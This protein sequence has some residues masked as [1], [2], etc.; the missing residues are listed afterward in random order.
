MIAKALAAL[1]CGYALFVL[2]RGRLWLPVTLPI[3]ARHARW[4]AGLWLG[5][6]LPA[7]VALAIWGKLAT[8]GGLAV[9]FAPL[10]RAIDLLPGMIGFGT[11]AAGLAGGSALGLV[12]TWWRARRGRAPWTAGDARSIMPQ[13][14]GELLPA[15]LLAVSA[16]VTEELFFRLALPLAVA[17]LS[18]SGL[19]GCVVGTGCFALQ[20]RYQGWIGVVATAIGGALMTGLYFGS[21]GLWLPIVAHALTDLN[22][23]VL[24][25]AVSAWLRRR[26]R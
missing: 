7:L 13:D 24:R 20:H 19:A 11:V 12:A 22:A 3:G 26:R 16:G 8:I 23:L 9:E 2:W 6:G 1:L 21:G 4:A 25:P 18:G 15:A 5:Y 14:G 17:M 10:A